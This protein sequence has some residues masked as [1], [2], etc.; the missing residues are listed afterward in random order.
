MQ[1]GAP[2]DLLPLRVFCRF[3]TGPHAEVLSALE[4]ISEEMKADSDSRIP[5][6][7]ENVM[8]AIRQLLA[9]IQREKGPTS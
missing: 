5:M 9:Q 4:K 6:Q 8:S 3:R 7:L 2:A 1:A